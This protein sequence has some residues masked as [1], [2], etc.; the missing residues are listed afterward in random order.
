MPRATRSGGPPQSA[1]VVNPTKKSSKKKRKA[2]QAGTTQKPGPTS[3]GANDDATEDAADARYLH[4][5]RLAKDL[6][7][8]AAEHPGAQGPLLDFLTKNW[9]PQGPDE[10]QFPSTPKNANL[11][12]SHDGQD[13]YVESSKFSEPERVVNQAIQFLVSVRAGWEPRSGKRTRCVARCVAA[14]DPGHEPLRRGAKLRRHRHRHRRQ[15]RPH[16]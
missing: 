9:K 14:L 2:R 12:V 3:A 5:I 1:A 4:L 6:R 10:V 7:D 11:S 16:A 13:D 8:A 15:H